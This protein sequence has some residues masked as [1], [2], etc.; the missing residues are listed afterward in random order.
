MGDGPGDLVPLPAQSKYSNQFSHPH[1]VGSGGD[2]LLVAF[3]PTYRELGR[4]PFI[5]GDFLKLDP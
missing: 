2:S 1:N 4:S 5:L 3:A